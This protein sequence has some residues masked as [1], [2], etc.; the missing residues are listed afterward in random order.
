MTIAGVGGICKGW[1]ERIPRDVLVVA[2]LILSSSAGFGLGYLAGQ[3]AGQGRGVTIE[4][5]PPTGAETQAVPQPAAAAA[6]AEGTGARV[7]VGQYVA[8]KNG[9]KYYLPSCVGAKRISEANKVWFATAAAA[10]A[11][12]YTPAANCPGL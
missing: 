2:A 7:L 12:G 9:T 5:V 4:V 8:S 11:E 6:A 10:T 3:G 1:L